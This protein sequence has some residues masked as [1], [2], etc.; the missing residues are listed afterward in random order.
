MRAG[1]FRGSGWPGVPVDRRPG[2]AER[3]PPASRPENRGLRVRA[4][5]WNLVWEIARRLPERVTFGIADVVGRLAFRLTPRSRQQ[6]FSNLLRVTGPATHPEEVLR[7]VRGA[8]R[9]YCRYWAEAFR[10]ADIAPADL[11]ARTTTEGFDHLDAALEQGRGAIVLLAH[12]GSWDLAARWAETHGYHLAVVAEIVRPRKLF[13]K[14]VRLREQIGLEVVPLRRGEDLAGRLE[15]VLAANHLVGLLSDRDLSG[16]G[17]P[18]RLFGEPCRIP[19]GPVT[20]ARR[21]GAPILPV[22]LRQEP[23][24]RWHL[25]VLPAI[26]VD[27]RDVD[28]AAQRVASGL[29]A[30]IRTDPA[31]WHAFSAI[32]PTDRPRVAVRAPV[33]TLPRD[34]GTS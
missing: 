19:H 33:R 31:Q 11:D 6:M 7:L 9:S 1:G 23:G 20:L 28:E 32:W 29:E 25:Q 17:I 26:E 10:A 13:E 22:T 3:I 5:V 34:V 21:T 14:F 16:N 2:A 27:G 24:R 15:E 18:V 12:H 30:I 4:F 8:F